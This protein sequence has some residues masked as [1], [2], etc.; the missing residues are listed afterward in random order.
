MTNVYSKNAGSNILFIRHSSFDIR[1]FPPSA[2]RFAR[3]AAGA[4]WKKEKDGSGYVPW[5]MEGIWEVMGQVG[6]LCNS[7]VSQVS[8]SVQLVRDELAQHQLL[9][10]PGAERTGTV[11]EQ[12]F[13]LSSAS[14][15]HAT[16]EL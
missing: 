7:E 4:R 15:S 8:P 6:S 16:Q 11:L 1:Y 9:V 14:R 13:S 10:S 5:G 12:V 2:F 3:C